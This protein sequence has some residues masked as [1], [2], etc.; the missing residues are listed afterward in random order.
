ML[1]SEMMHDMIIR[2]LNEPLLQALLLFRSKALSST[3]VS[4]DFFGGWGQP[5]AP[6]IILVTSSS[7]KA[8]LLP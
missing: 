2:R 6:K 8:S 4:A 3:V 7:R 1:C 5:D